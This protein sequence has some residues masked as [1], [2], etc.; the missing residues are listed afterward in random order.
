MAKTTKDKDRRAVVEE[1]RKQQQRAEKRR[2]RV[3]FLACA[4]VALAIIGL[5]AYPLISRS[6]SAWCAG[7]AASTPIDFGPRARSNQ[8]PPAM[9]VTVA[10]PRS[11]MSPAAAMSQVDSP[12]C[13]TNASN[14]PFAT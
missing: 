10:R 7:G 8:G 11:A 1:M 3:I 2:T 14:R 4:V 9:S 5:G 13:W 6:N 12:P